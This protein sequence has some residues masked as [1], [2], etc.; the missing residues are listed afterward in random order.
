MKIL[1][2]TTISNTVN[3]FL[4]P[5]I[6]MLIEQGHKVDVAFNIVQE[7]DSKLIELGC[8]VHKLEFTR[9]PIK[10]QNFTAYKKL[11]KIIQNEQYDLV[12][13][14]TPI[15]SACVRLACRK[16]V[17]VKVIYTAHGFHFYKGAPL[18]NWIIFYS[19]ERIVAHFTDS[20]ITMNKEDFN[21]AK[22]M[23]LKTND[24]VYKINGIGVNLNKFTP[25]N[26][27]KKNKLRMEFGYNQD[28]LIL[29]YAAELNSNKHQDLL[30]NAVKLLKSK[31]PNVK[32]LLAG[33][34][35]LRENY[36][37]QV[38]KLGL[39]GNVEFLGFRK[40][41]PELLSITD[42]AV[43]SSRREGLPVNIMEAMAIGLPLVVTNCRGQRDLVI[44]GEN[45][46][47]VGID[48]YEDFANSIEKLYKLKQLR[49]QFGEKSI[50]LVKQYSL[51]NVMKEMKDVY[52]NYL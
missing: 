36:E 27:N 3:T 5:H 52:K 44:D 48:D 47:V 9:I 17:N 34:G 33:N 25:Q 8:T 24:S 32:L 42:I 38:K 43:A 30:I 18:R 1:F 6:R 49:Q 29:F 37:E 19:M 41:I 12:H 13:T 35:D 28:D 7:V 51:E 2:V 21:A 50:K 39:Q 16:M 23:K 46:F 20:I 40:D 22:K 14:H 15:A 26:L 31:I 10:K 45:G 11:K 4:I